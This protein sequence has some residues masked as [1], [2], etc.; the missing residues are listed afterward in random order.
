M[1]F[2]SRAS[3]TFFESTVLESNDSTLSFMKPWIILYASF[4]SITEN[5]LVTL[6]WITESE[7]NNLGF[8]VYRALEE[9]ADYVLLSNYKSN[10][11]L[12]GQGNSSIRHEYSY[13][14]ESAEPETTYW[15]KLAD[16]DYM[17]VKTFHGP[18]SVTAPKAIP[19]AFKLQP[20]YP[21]PFNPITTV[22]FDI[23]L[24]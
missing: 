22:R 11:E 24:T 8:E 1:R 2:F 14:D 7:I 3:K 20:N 19:T 16:L 6:K 5:G 23:P 10:P 9:D 15:Y 21:N 4:K 13:T 18:V 17:G 12:E